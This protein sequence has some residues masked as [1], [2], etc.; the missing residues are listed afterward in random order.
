MSS[1]HDYKLASILIADRFTISNPSFIGETKAIIYLNNRQQSIYVVIRFENLT[2]TINYD[3]DKLLYKNPL[4]R[5]YKDLYKTI[6][7]FYMKYK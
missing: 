5:N 4:S 6:H 3:E 1:E 2:P 7:D